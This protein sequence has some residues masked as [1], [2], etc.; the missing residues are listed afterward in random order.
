MYKLT[1]RFGMIAFVTI[2]TAVILLGTGYRFVAVSNLAKFGE[3]QNVMLAQSLANALWPHFHG[4]VEPNATEVTDFDR[5]LLL[6]VFND[7]VLPLIEGLPVLKVNL[8]NLA[9][10]TMYSTNE[11]EFGNISTNEKIEQAKND[12][13][14]SEIKHNIN[15]EGFLGIQRHRDIL[16][17]Y[18]PIRNGDSG[19]VEGIIEIHTD[20]TPFVTVIK[21]TQYKVFAGVLAI[22]GLTYAILFYFVRN[23]DTTIRIQVNTIQ[24]L[25]DSMDEKLKRATKDLAA[26]R[27]E[28]VAANQAKSMFLANMSHEL[29]TPLNAIIGYSE[30][31][32]D[33]FSQY[34][35]QELIDDLGKIMRSGHNLLGLV[36][37]VLDLSKIEAGKMELVV[38]QLNV[39][40][41]IEEI[42]DIIA[43]SVQ[44]NGNQLIVE[45]DHKVEA[46]MADG[47]RLKQILLNLLNNA[48]KFTEQ[49]TIT[50]SVSMN[51][52]KEKNWL[53]IR[54]ADTGI[55]MTEEQR[56]RL[57]K[58]FSQADSSIST[59]YGGT[60]LGLAIS[61]RFC[62]MMG[63]DITVQSEKDQGSVF[64]VALPYFLNGV[65]SSNI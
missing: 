51:I 10:V 61:Q 2:V 25:N 9:N 8:Y 17:S 29:R 58:E 21:H 38:A 33:D 27:D 31:A 1:R 34:E 22:L 24:S 12:Q 6:P 55:G 36:S 5:E 56:Q 62:R 30:M 11:A 19:P 32:I 3:Q 47:T 49:G 50:T 44:K 59:K 64:T 37:D 26:A 15:F 7:E 16:S 52:E 57:F 46:I 43:P 39:K 35:K 4:F 23:A 48:C 63:G 14:T 13:V 45:M 65:K 18:L 40:E 54:I 42:A 60:G 53:R 20:I 41:L 28:A